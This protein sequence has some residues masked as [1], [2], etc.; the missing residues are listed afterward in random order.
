MNFGS[1]ASEEHKHLQSTP[2]YALDR[3]NLYTQNSLL[4]YEFELMACMHSKAINALSVIILPGIKALW[5]GEMI[6]CSKEI[7]VLNFSTL[8]QIRVLIGWTKL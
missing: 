5:L 8:L 2:S 3:S 7:K 1:P 4:S 6:S